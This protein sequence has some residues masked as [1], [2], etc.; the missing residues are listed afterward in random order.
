MIELK[1]LYKSFSGTEALRDVSLSI[2]KGCIYGIIG[3]SGAGKSTLLRCINLLEK[4]DK[5]EVYFQGECLSEMKEKTLRE[6]RQKIGM[7]FQHFAL[8]RT[9]TVFDNIAFPLKRSGLSKQEIKGRVLELLDLVELSDKVDA[10]PSELSGGQKQ[11]VAIARALANKPE[12]LLSDEGTSALDPETTSS[13]LSLLGKLNRELG[14]TVV[15]ITH[16]IEV[17]RSICRRAAVMDDG[18]VLEEGEVF[19]LFASPKHP[20]TR[21]LL[22]KSSHLSKVDELIQTDSPLV[23][24]NPGEKLLHFSYVKKSVA[25]PLLSTISQRFHVFLNIILSDV[26]VLGETPVGGIIAILSGSEE[27]QQAAVNYM[28]EKEVCVEVLKYE[29]F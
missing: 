12:V 15:L 5:G 4:P 8:L 3:S 26:Q 11:R 25:E 22:H 14:L 19:D 27:D 18:R 17:L 2:P 1:H 9:R 23:R 20:V 10:Y 28:R 21:R 29:P 16:Q 24:L 7:I 6:K 13:I